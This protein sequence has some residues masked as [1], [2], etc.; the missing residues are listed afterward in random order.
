MEINGN[1]LFIKHESGNIGHFFNDHVYSSF[2]YYLMNKEKIHH[3]Y[4]KTDCNESM[5]DI[6]KENFKNKIF[7][8]EKSKSFLNFNMIL[9]F[10]YNENKNIYIE[11]FSENNYIFQ[12]LVKIDS[13]RSLNNYHYLEV[14]HHLLKNYKLYLQKYNI[15]IQRKDVTVLYRTTDKFERNIYNIEILENLFK[16]Q[17]IDYELLDT[18]KHF[19]FLEIVRIF[20]FSDNIISFHGCELT[21]GIF[22]EKNS[23]II[24]L[25]KM[26]HIEKWW[27]IMEKKFV[28]Y[29]LKYTRFEVN[30][31][32]KHL[33]LN[34][35]TCFNILIKVINLRIS[36]FGAS[37]TEQ[38]EGYVYQIKKQFEN[39]T[40]ISIFQHGYGAR[41]ITDSGII[42]IDDVLLN[43][44]HFCFL[45]W[46][47]TLLVCDLK[48]IL[49]FL[50]TIIYKFTKSNCKLI[51]LF[52][53]RKDM[54]H[55][56]MEMYHSVQNY[57]DSNKIS[58]LDLSE[59]FNNDLMECILKDDVHTTIQGGINYSIKIIDY[60]KNNM[61]HINYPSTLPKETPFCNYIKKN[62]KATIHDYIE[63]EGKGEIISFKIIKNK[64]CG[65]VDIFQNNIYEKSYNFWDKWCS[66]TR[67]SLACSLLINGKTTICLTNKNVDINNETTGLDWSTINKTIE[68]QDIYFI[69]D[70]KITNFK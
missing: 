47:S 38:K 56:R 34:N 41:Y 44:P 1:T 59:R 22:M 5:V 8:E 17:N 58:Y 39:N 30:L 51:F 68:I 55:D 63:I 27:L 12:N 65:I 36:F 20:H 60:F 28:Q 69:G 25:T 9:M 33:Y 15:K 53:P 46:F 2:G 48:D 26:N 16:T 19:G 42:N 66:W 35:E 43:K 40:S 21:Y 37:I 62:F 23:Q 61:N 67:E 49:I 10:L 24:E 6:F 11:N 13:D 70:I 52:F 29:G 64:H 32:N 57:L 7:S 3:I 45:D 18:S 4:I 54:N 14:F 31:K 50:E